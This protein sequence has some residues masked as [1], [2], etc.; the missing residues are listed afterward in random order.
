MVRTAYNF[1]D[2]FQ[3]L[4]LK[5]NIFVCKIEINYTCFISNIRLTRLI[6]QMAEDATIVALTAHPSGAH[7][8]TP[9]F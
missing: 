8:F 9:H 5:G 1:T 2:V 6:R 7:E 3:D 4:Q